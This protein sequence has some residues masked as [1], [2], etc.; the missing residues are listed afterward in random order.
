MDHAHY[1]ACSFGY[2]RLR[3][4]GELKWSMIPRYILTITLDFLDTRTTTSTSESEGWSTEPRRIQEQ[5]IYSM[6]HIGFRCIP[7]SLHGRVQFLC[8]LHSTYLDFMTSFNV[9]WYERNICW[10]H[11]R[12]CLLSHFY[13]ECKL[14]L[15][16]NIFWIFG[17]PLWCEFKKHSLRVFRI[18]RYF[19]FIGA[20]NVIVPFTL[21]AA[22][23]TYAW[24]FATTKGSLILIAV[25]YG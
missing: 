20:I 15:C 3:E 14:G 4:F 17:R 23:T 21:L 9:Y 19:I 16:S 5:G 7:W 11:A 18:A 10:H 24:P 8:L 6:V 12:L 22:I 13:C 25:F 1:R 2:A